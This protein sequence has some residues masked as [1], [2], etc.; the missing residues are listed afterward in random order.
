[1]ILIKYIER[2]I[3]LILKFPFKSFISL[4]NKNANVVIISSF[5]TTGKFG[6]ELL[7]RELGYI[8]YCCDNDIEFYFG[9]LSGSFKNKIIFWAPNLS[10]DK[11]KFDNY[12]KV[13]LDLATSI[14][15]QGNKLFPSSKELLFLENKKFMHDVLD[16]FNINTPKTWSYDKLSEIEYDVLEFPLL[17]KGAHSSGSKDIVKFENLNELK[18]FISERDTWEKVILQKLVNMRRD[19]RVTIV[20]GEFFSAFWRINEK[21]EWQVTATS[22]GSRLEITKIS[23]KLLNDLKYI[24][25]LC[26]L[27]TAGIDV[28][29]ENDD[30]Q[31]DPIILE[32]SPLFSINPYADLS[33][34][35]YKYGKFKKKYFIKNS[36]GSLQQKELIEI[37]Y[38]YFGSKYS[39]IFNNHN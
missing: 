14:E 33:N 7:I 16:K 3:L 12:S 2:F 10:I 17:W 23:E 19:M 20:E 9:K 34:K 26:D 36:Y 39:Q 11:Y 15:A 25:D 21:E 27:T 30:I 24:M 35:K 13:I 37:T 4:Y 28:C 5:L 22:L 6:R 38:S 1:M 29:W 31:G 32:L 8:R 18:K